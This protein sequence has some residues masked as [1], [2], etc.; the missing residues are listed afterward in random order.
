MV[1]VKANA[2]S[3]RVAR[4]EKASLKRVRL[5]LSNVAKVSLSSALIGEKISLSGA[6]GLGLF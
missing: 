4:L 3:F 1:E 5:A 2:C 6:G